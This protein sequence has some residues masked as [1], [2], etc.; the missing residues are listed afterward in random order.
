[1]KRFKNFVSEML[2]EGIRQGLPAIK[3][4][5][6]DQFHG[7]VSGGKLHLHSG[8]MTEKTDGVTH[9][10]HYDEHGF[11]TQSSGSGSEI[12]RSPE[13]FMT[14]AVRRSNETGKPISH[15]AVEM[16]SHAH[17][18]LASNGPLQAYL[19]NRYEKTGKPVKLRGELFYRPNSVPSDEHENHIKFVA[20]PYDTSHMGSVGKYVIHTKLPD[21]QGHDFDHLVNRAS[22][23]ELNF[24]T[25]TIHVPK[26]VSID[27]TSFRHAFN[28]LDHGLLKTPARTK[29]IKAV[30]EKELA[31]FQGIKD[32]FSD[33]VDHH[34]KSMGLSPKWGAGSEGIVIHHNP[35][36]KATSAAFRKYRAAIEADP[37][38]SRFKK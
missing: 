19:K 21:N 16:F 25:D 35:R 18:I 2:E 33:H 17:K 14:R 22:T 20:T 26:K 32:A 38:K 6:T 3:T 13:D 30:K 5:S 37:S 11:G 34:I 23:H 27:T 31:K 1:M 4:M 10:M 28:D 15:G 7:L 9:M 24:D 12:M 8:N 36:F 29:E